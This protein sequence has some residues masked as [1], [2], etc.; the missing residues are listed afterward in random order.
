[1]FCVMVLYWDTRLRAGARFIKPWL[2]VGLVLGTLMVTGHARHELVG[3]IA[4]HALP[5]QLDPVAARAR[6]CGNGARRGPGGKP[7]RPR[8]QTS[9]SHRQRTM[10]SRVC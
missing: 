3:K 10:A 2:A 9:L 7:A 6:L 1:M 5:A 4:G 8:R